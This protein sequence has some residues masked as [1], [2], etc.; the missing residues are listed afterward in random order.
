MIE[1]RTDWF[2]SVL[3]FAA[4]SSWERDNHQF[5]QAKSF[6]FEP[7]KSSPMAEIEVFN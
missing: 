4:L 5:F 3:D 6:D 2:E 1:S 7:Y